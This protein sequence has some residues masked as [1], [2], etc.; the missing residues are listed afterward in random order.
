MKAYLTLITTIALTTLSAFAELKIGVVDMAILIRN[1][2]DYE[3]N[4][5]LLESTDRDYKE[6]LEA[7][8]KEGDKLQSDG[9]RYVEQMRNPML[10]DKSKAEAEK[11][12]AQIQ[13]R[14]MEIEQRYRS[15]AINFQQELADLQVRLMKAT[16]DELKKTIDEYAN[17][18]GYDLI[19][20]SNVALFAKK[21]IDITNEI[22]SKMGV[23]PK[24]AKGRELTNEGK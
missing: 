3:R 7:I 19:C 21:S 11:N 8:K 24:T 6:K 13:E 20:D 1:H 22:L 4:E 23:D 15:K 17:E 10:T 14:L 16:T 18:Q 9:K 12:I 5:K 2:R